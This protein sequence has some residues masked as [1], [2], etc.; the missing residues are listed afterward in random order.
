MF[1]QFP[2][3]L[4]GTGVPLLRERPTLGLQSKD[5]SHGPLWVGV[6]STLSSE[7]HFWLAVFSDLMTQKWMRREG[8]EEHTYLNPPIHLSVKSSVY[9]LSFTS[10]FPIFC[11][12]QRELE[13]QQSLSVCIGR[14]RLQTYVLRV[15]QAINLSFE[16]HCG[17][18]L[19]CSSM[20]RF[21]REDGGFGCS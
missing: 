16:L 1:F 4:C 9:V 5:S 11:L 14:H 10:G 20:S 8:H 2:Y 6:K 21:G 17:N 13:I 15:L 18:V 3:N 19:R 12:G 7:G